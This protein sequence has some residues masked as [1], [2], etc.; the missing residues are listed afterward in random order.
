MNLWCLPQLCAFIDG[1]QVTFPIHISDR[2]SGTVVLLVFFKRLLLGL[3]GND[4]RSEIYVI[5]IHAGDSLKAII[6][7][8]EINLDSFT[9]IL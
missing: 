5:D 2:E 9:G 7:H 6:N 1:D 8:V 4:A 3:W